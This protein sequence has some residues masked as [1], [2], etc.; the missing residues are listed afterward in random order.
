MLVNCFYSAICFLYADNSCFMSLDFFSFFCFFFFFFFFSCCTV[1]QCVWCFSFSVCVCV[2]V[3][4]GEK[5]VGNT[6]D[7]LNT[8]LGHKWYYS[9]QRNRFMFSEWSQ[10]VRK[11]VWLHSQS[12]K[13]KSS[14]HDRLF[15]RHQHWGS[16][17]V[18]TWKLD[19]DQT[20]MAH[21]R[22]YGKTQM[23]S[24]SLFVA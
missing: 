12:V 15:C 21:T 14:V 6:W 3:C 19:L 23:W 16:V 5:E 17:H 7:I 13:S 8:T 18:V 1:Y 20:P 2:C 10:N 22:S 4:G 9:N 24:N 11:L